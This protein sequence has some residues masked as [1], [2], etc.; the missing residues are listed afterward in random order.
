MGIHSGLALFTT[1]RYVGLEVHRAT[2][3]AAAGHGGQVVVSQAAVE[4]VGKSECPLPEGTRLRDLGAHWLPGLARPER[5]AQLVLPAGSGLPVTFPPLRTQ[6]AWPWLRANLVLI[7][8]LT[9]ILL[10]FA[11]LVLP[12]AVPAFPR[13]PG[14]IAGGLTVLL[15]VVG[16]VAGLLRQRGHGRLAAW[17]QT[18]TRS[19]TATWRSAQLSMAALVSLLLSVVLVAM[20]LFIT[21]PAPL[22]IAQPDSYNF[23]Y[24]PHRPTHTG[25]SV[26]IGTSFPLHTLIP[27]TLNGGLPDIA[28][29]AIWSGCLVQ[30]PDLKLGLR[31]WRADQCT[32]VPTI[33]NGDVN[34]EETRTILHIDPRAVWSDGQPLLAADFLFAFRLMQDPNV[35]GA[36]WLGGS[37]LVPPFSLMHL[38]A[39]DAQTVV[40]EWTEPYADYLSALAQLTPLPLHAFARGTYA[41]VYDPITYTY[42]SELAQKMAADASFNL[43]IPV[44]NGPFTVEHVDYPWPYRANEVSIAPRVVLTRNPRYFSNFFHHPAALDRVTFLVKW[45]MAGNPTVANSLIAAY[46]QGGLTLSDGMGLPV[47]SQLADVPAREVVT[48]PAPALIVLG[49]NQRTVA[50]NARANGGASIFSDSRVRLAFTQAFDRCRA[51][52]DAYGVQNCASSPY[53]TDELSA[54]PA[55]DFDP[56]FSLPPYD[57]IAA[58]ALLE[59][60]G[61]HDVQ[62]VRHLQDGVTPLRL[63]LA[64][65]FGSTAY[66]DTLGSRLKQEYERNLHVAVQILDDRHRLFD[67]T[68][69]DDPAVTGDF[70]MGVF[71]QDNAPDPVGSLVSWGWDGMSI[72]PNGSNFLGVIDPLVPALDQQGSHIINDDQRAEVYQDLTRHV[73]QEYDYL[74]L[75]VNASM[76]LVKPT[77]CNFKQW[78]EFGAYL[79]NMADWY[80]ARGSTCP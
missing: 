1:G 12:L 11:G 14:L 51:L 6:D 4:E 53:H 8:G 31:G 66:V 67:P 56:A 43:T 28:Y 46:Q 22:T 36:V 65:S 40:I 10:T 38:I 44:D 58:A 72:P 54:P 21:M 55:A 16:G 32:R 48:S 30:L 71:L 63:T 59:L 13:A 25:G 2:R 75:L 15:L 79:W 47:L 24:A 42:N 45:T 26:V 80:L 74:P 77:L 35:N 69:P 50:P 23:T 18:V 27:P 52:R 37:P 76:V 3:I 41:G 64:F 60:A 70:D 57:P 39:A 73:A 78:P 34:I 5:L 17:S 33:G 19:P 49:F 20:T 61:F 68:N 9:L 7:A 62:G 29:R